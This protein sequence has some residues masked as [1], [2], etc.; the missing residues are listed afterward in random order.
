MVYLHHESEK[1][2]ANLFLLLG[3]VLITPL[4]WLILD[5]LRD[6]YRIPSILSITSVSILFI[7]GFLSI[8]NSYSIMVNKEEKL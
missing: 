8:V 6:N 3:T 2:R 4:C 7:F 1:F 5:Y